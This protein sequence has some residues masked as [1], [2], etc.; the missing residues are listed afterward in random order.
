MKFLSEKKKKCWH[1]LFIWMR[2]GRPYFGVQSL[3]LITFLSSAHKNNRNLY[4]RTVQV[5][6]LHRS[7]LLLR[8]KI[9][10][11]IFFSRCAKNV[12]YLPELARF[13]GES[14]IFGKF[15]FRGWNAPENQISLAENLSWKVALESW[16]VVLV[17]L[18]QWHALGRDEQAKYYELARR[19]RQL[20]MQ[21][22]PDWSSRA[23]QTRGKKRKRNN[24]QEPNDSGTTNQLFI[25]V[26]PMSLFAYFCLFYGYIFC[27]FI[28]I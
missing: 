10:E 3:L 15:E 2:L 25:P 16:V 18:I 7:T 12:G 22:Y 20:H 6:L 21:L 23:N 5:V 4:F 19:E 1:V 28:R 26:S 24:K 14:N 27:M 17:C 13:A 11:A 9:S 8:S